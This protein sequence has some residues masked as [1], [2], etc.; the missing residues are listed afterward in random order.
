MRLLRFLD[1]RYTGQSY[2]L[3]VAFAAAFRKEFSRLHLRKYGY[4]DE[5]RPVEVVNLRVKA[6]G[7]TEKPRLVEVEFRGKDAR[8]AR[9]DRRPM[10]FE[11][12]TYQADVYARGML[13]AG[14][15]ING[16]ALILDY[17][18]TAV[19][20]PS[21]ICSVDKHGNLIIAQRRSR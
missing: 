3:T 2:E 9:I 14:N 18:S 19:V 4:S 20:P 12:R 17:E 1:V 10:R 11:S 16:P 21:C 7:V 15:V 8:P 13:G 6:V 5:K